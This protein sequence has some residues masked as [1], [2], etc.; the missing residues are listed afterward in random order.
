MSIQIQLPV[1]ALYLVEKRVNYKVYEI[2]KQLNFLERGVGRTVEKW[3]TG[4]T[5]ILDGKGF[6]LSLKLAKVNLFWE[7][8]RS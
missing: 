5:C 1:W 2:R 6:L 4:G 7:D 3:N 8:W